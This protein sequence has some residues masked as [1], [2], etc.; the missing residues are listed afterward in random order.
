[1]SAFEPAGD[2]EWMSR[3]LDEAAK[4][5]PSPNP[6]VG[7]VLVKDGALLSVGHHERAGAEHAEVMAIARAGESTRGATL[8]CTLE[9]C[10]HHGRTPP[11]TEAIL[12][13]G[14]ARVVISAADP[15]PHVPGA[16][17]RLEAAG[18]E[19]RL[20]VHEEEG[21]RLIA[22]F[23]RHI[24]TG[25]PYVISKAAV[26]LD[27]RTA[28]RTG[29][30]KWIT[31][32]AARRE[33][34]RMRAQAD[35]VLVGVGT[36]VADD[37][38][39]TVRHVDGRDPY[40]IVLDTSLRTPADAQLVLHESR[41]PTWIFHGPDA[42]TDRRSKLA[43]EGVELIEAP[44]VEGRL[45]LPDIMR[46]L[47]ARG[48]VRVLAEGGA[49]VHGALLEAELVSAMAVFVA[50]VILGDPEAIPLARAGGIERVAEGRRL[51]A[52]RVRVLGE[53]VLVEGE[54]AMTPSWAKPL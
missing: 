37:P 8:Y 3:A 41:R 32:E 20:G 12:K 35:A 2:E 34:H 48:I 11:C 52:P 39:L 42:S 15:L 4:G 5:D 47:G 7:A 6:H 14:I 44:T 30:S 45:S 18:V 24:R 16:I 28:A 1:M 53:D 27:G 46:E 25:L 36:V 21:S 31:G 23:A 51:V 26:T 17:A 9:P 40:R 49:T 50:P 43:R 13:A 10:N 38:S 33:A 22:D 29:D 54:L 19:V